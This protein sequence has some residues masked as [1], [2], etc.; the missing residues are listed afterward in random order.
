MAH[1]DSFSAGTSYMADESEVEADAEAMVARVLS[2]ASVRDES[3]LVLC[4][5]SLTDA[6]EIVKR[7]ERLFARKVHSVTIMGGVERPDEMVNDVGFLSAGWTPPMRRGSAQPAGRSPLQGSPAARAVSSSPW[8]LLE[9][10]SAN[11]N[12][13]DMAAAQMLYKRVQELGIRLNV[14]TRYAAYGAPVPR[15]VYDEMAATGSPIAARLISVQR[16]SIEQ[17][18]KRCNA[19]GAARRGLPPRCNRS[20][21]CKTFL[22]GR[23]AERDGDDS[24][25]DLVQHFNMYDPM[26]LLL[27]C[28]HLSWKFFTHSCLGDAAR[29]ERARV[30]GVSPSKPGIKQSDLLRAF[31]IEGLREGMA[32]SMR[33]KDLDPI[34]EN[35]D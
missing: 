2:D 23:G 30:V 33:N 34:N 16:A 8:R 19:T 3:V 18:W 26:T 1:T 6:A 7:H 17:L 9:P 27:A 28:P 4:I 32:L 15:G 29:G 24:V 35:G 13:F 21:F 5:S 14:L 22:G 12:T 20:W 11:N 25:W 31:L 10:D